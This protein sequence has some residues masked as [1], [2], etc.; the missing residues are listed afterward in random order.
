MLFSTTEDRVKKLEKRLDSLEKDMKK[1]LRDINDSL[2]TITEVIS[3]LQEE[4]SELKE[5]K[6]KKEKEAINAAKIRVESQIRGLGHGID[7]KETVRP[8]K[9]I[10]TENYEFVQNVAKEGILP[11]TD[12]L[13]RLVEK[14]RE[15][16]IQ[17]AAA[18]LKVHVLQI[19]KWSDALK[20]EKLISVAEKNNKKYLLT[21]KLHGDLHET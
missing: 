13:L 10:I 9:E 15:I 6:L 21:S 16:S 4:N 8:L 1:V 11:G 5:E 14:E 2:I 20:A 7:I 17:A 3:K 19:E 18:K 12:K